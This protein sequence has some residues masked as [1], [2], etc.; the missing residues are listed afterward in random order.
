MGGEADVLGRFQEGGE[1]EG[2]G[3]R[4]VAGA[5]AG[6]GEIGGELGVVGELHAGALKGGGGIGGTAQAQEADRVADEGVGLFGG[7]GE[8]ECECSFLGG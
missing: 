3:A 2:E 1:E 6:E 4:G 5:V 7:G 8:A